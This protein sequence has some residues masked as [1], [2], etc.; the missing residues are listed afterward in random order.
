MTKEDI[1]SG[2]AR[3]TGLPQQTCAKVFDVALSLIA[4]ELKKG[5]TVYTGGQFGTF[6]P[7]DLPRS[8]K[9]FLGNPI[10]IPA[11]RKVKFRPSAKL[12]SLL[13][14][15]SEGGSDGGAL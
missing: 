15:E 1:I 3:E 2:V 10:D 4:R 13:N 5:N 6:I 11:R 7:K 14:G 9:V 12:K 8:V